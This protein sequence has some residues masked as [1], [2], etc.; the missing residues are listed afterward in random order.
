MRAGL[1]VDAHQF[2][3]S[4]TVVLAGVV[5][6][7]DRGVA[8]TSDGDVVA[9]AVMDALLGAAALGD[10]GDLFPSDD[11]RWAGADSMELLATVVQRLADLAL[12]VNN[13][14]VTVV[15]QTVRVAPLRDQIRRNLASVVGVPVTGVAVKGTTTDHLGFLGRD[16]GIAALAVVTL[17]ERI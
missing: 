1:G 14:D 2:T 9:H 7:A 11:P 8:A 13:V 15:A 10:L 3:A 16:E 5:A 17:A 6:S 12:H 4:G